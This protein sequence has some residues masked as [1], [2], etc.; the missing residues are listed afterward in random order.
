M[1]ESYFEVGKPVS[2]N[3]FISR[4]K[5]LTSKNNFDF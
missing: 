1:L 2:N 3:K 5:Q 4:E